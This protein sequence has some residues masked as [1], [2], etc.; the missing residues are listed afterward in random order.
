MTVDRVRCRYP[1]PWAELQGL[2]FQSENTPAQN[3]AFYELREDGSLW[4]R[5]DRVMTPPRPPLPG[6]TASSHSPGVVQSETWELV[7]GIL[8]TH[9]YTIGTHIRYHLYVSFDNDDVAYRT[10]AVREMVDG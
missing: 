5:T 10:L 9:L 4:V 7:F 3:D 8:E 1:L 6:Q 2:V